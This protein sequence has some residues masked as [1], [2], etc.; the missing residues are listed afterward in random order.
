M[1]RDLPDFLKR[2][3]S[4]HGEKLKQP[5]YKTPGKPKGGGPYHGSQA[6]SY[7]SSKG[8][9]GGKWGGASVGKEKGYG[10]AGHA[11]Q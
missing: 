11:S 4:A 5:T 1:C 6:H 8:G 9:K 2:A 3:S 7:Q 10:K